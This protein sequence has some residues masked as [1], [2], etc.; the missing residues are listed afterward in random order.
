METS[1]G[2][3]EVGKRFCGR[4]SLRPEKSWY[5]FGAPA[6]RAE[7]RIKQE[8]DRLEIAIEWKSSDGHTFTMTNQ[9]IPDGQEYPYHDPLIADT[10]SATFANDRTLDTTSLKDGEIIL[11]ARR[12][13]L[14]DGRSM[15]VT[16]TGKTAQGTSFSNISFYERQPE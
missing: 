7:Y 6:Q 2:Y 16:Q 1:K 9:F 8:D 15:I 13:L 5:E 4:W 3:A 14:E 12:E 11:H 10:V